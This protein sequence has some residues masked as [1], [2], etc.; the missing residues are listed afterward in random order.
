MTASSKCLINAQFQQSNWRAR[1]VLH[2]DMV[3]TDRVH[4]TLAW[5]RRGYEKYPRQFS[6]S[7]LVFFLGMF[8]THLWVIPFWHWGIYR[9]DIPLPAVLAD[10]FFRVWQG[11]DV[12]RAI[13][14]SFFGSVFV[15]SFIVRRDSL[16][17]LGVRLDTIRTSG[18]ECLVASCVL[19]S[20]AVAI[21]LASPDAFSFEKYV[22]RGFFDFLK[23]ISFCVLWGIFQQF[24]LQSVVLVRALHIFKRQSI[25]V[26]VSAVLFSLVHAP[27]VR[28]MILTLVFGGL[29][30]LLFLRN[31]NIVTLGVMHGIVHK[32]LAM[33]FASLLVSGLGYYDY[34]LRVGPVRSDPRLFAHLEYRGGPLKAHPSEEISVPVSVINKSISK[35]DSGDEELPVFMSYHMLD[36]KGEMVAFDNRRT[37][38]DKAVEP[39]G[40]TVVNLVVNVPMEAG[41]YY[42]EV[43]IVKERVA[44]FKDKGSRTVLIPLSAR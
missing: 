41:E 20:I 18:R 14:V 32:I 40:A 22:N 37:P 23:D 43:D 27:N 3:F 33:L 39:G 17:E 35:W 8:V 26:V 42:V 2:K 28:L 25:A 13:L 12:I 19:L 1:H 44:W 30:C 34:N 31:R 16:K 21:V 10:V 38:F 7:E 29:C 4:L 9:L 24:L 11:K 6:L 36:A 15:L 5:L